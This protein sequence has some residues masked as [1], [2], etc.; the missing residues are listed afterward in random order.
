MKVAVAVVGDTGVG[1]T[2]MLLAY[3]TGRFPSNC[4]EGSVDWHSE[5]DHLTRHPV[6]VVIG[7]VEVNITLVDTVGLDEYQKL[8]AVVCASAD[9]YLVCFDVTKPAT[10]ERVRHHWIPEIREYNSVAPFVLVATKCDERIAAQIEGRSSRDTV[11]FSQARSAG[12]EL[13]AITYC[14]CS[15]RNLTGLKK[16]F[17]EA[18]AAGL[19]KAYPDGMDKK[20][21]C[22][23][24]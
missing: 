17:E 12:Q 16:I 9:V 8:R 22:V 2:C 15:A 13:G 4:P 23:L 18:A 3:L 14:E 11:S 24:A 10:L 7:D 20:N 5:F 19:K 1:K 21:G 6:Q